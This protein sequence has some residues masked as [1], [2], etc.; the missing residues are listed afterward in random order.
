MS[1]LGPSEGMTR[2]PSEATLRVD[3]AAKT[4]GFEQGRAS[5]HKGI[6]DAHVLERMPLIKGLTQW[7]IGEFSQQQR[8]EERSRTPSKPLMHGNDWPVVLLNLLFPQSQVGDKRDVKSS[9][10]HFPDSLG[11]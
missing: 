8:P 5:S 7:N 4:I 11:E 9:L 6:E 2:V 1:A 10:N 3:C